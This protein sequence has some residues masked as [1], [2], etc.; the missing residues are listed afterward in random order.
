[1]VELTG[2]IGADIGTGSRHNPVPLNALVIG[3]GWSLQLVLIN[4]FWHRLLG[5]N[6]CLCAPTINT[7]PPSPL[8]AAVNA[9][10]MAAE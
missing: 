5:T 2:A 3:T 9:L 1:M 10:F 4:N 8:Q 6:Q 7:P